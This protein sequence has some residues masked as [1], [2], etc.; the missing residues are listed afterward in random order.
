MIFTPYYDIVRWRTQDLSYER[1]TPAGGSGGSRIFLGGGGGANSQS[2]CANLF[3]SE[4]LHEN[5][6]IWTPKRGGES[7]APSLDPPLEGINP[8]LYFPKNTTELKKIWSVRCARVR[9]IKSTT[10][11]LIFEAR[12]N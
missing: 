10:V 5:E 4:K 1:R 3:F 6:R 11:V 12:T 9:P 8:I 7:L 2:W